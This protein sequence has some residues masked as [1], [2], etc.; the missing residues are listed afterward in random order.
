MAIIIAPHQTMIMVAIML[1]LPPR[2]K[3][4]HAC[5]A[6]ISIVKTMPDVLPVPG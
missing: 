1:S 2:D 4:T 6:S 3:T 5:T